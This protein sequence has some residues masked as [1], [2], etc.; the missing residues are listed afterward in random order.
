MSGGLV[1]SMII[2]RVYASVEKIFFYKSCA[3]IHRSK[4]ISR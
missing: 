2:T 1:W 3:L 4:V